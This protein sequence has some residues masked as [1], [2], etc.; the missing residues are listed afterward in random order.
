MGAKSGADHSDIYESKNF[1]AGGL[2]CPGK[3]ADPV[4]I[5]SSKGAKSVKAGAHADTINH[6]DNVS[7]VIP[8]IGGKKQSSIKVIVNKVECNALLD[9]GADISVVNLSFFNRHVNSQVR[10]SNFPHALT[11][12]G[13]H[14]A[15]QGSADI[16]IIID[17]VLCSIEAVITEDI[18][19]DLILGVDFLKS[20]QGRIDFRNNRFEFHETNCVPLNLQTEIPVY[21]NCN[22]YLQPRTQQIV[23]AKVRVNLP[24]GTC[25]HLQPNPKLP[26]LQSV[27]AASSLSQISQSSVNILVMNP[28]NDVIKIRKNQCIAMLNAVDN[29][30]VQVVELTTSDEEGIDVGNVN[31]AH[32][33]EC[34]S[35]AEMNIDI[36]QALITEEQRQE[37]ENLILQYQDI[38]ALT[39]NDIGRT[40][41]IMHHIPTKDHAPIRLRPYRESPQRREIIRK[42]VQQ[43]EQAGLITKATGAWAFPVVL[44]KK[45]N[46]PDSS[47]F[48]F[49]VD[50]RKLNA[51]TDPCSFPLPNIHDYIQEL[52][53]EKIEYM[54]SMDVKSAFFQ[55][56]LTPEAQE[57][58]TFITAD[59][60]MKFLVMP[61]GLMAASQTF[62]RFL[63][64]ALASL[65]PDI[66]LCYI[67]DILVRSPTWELHLEHLRR[68]FI[69]LRKAGIKLKPSKCQFVRQELQFLGHLISKQGIR[70]LRR[71]IEKIA[72]CN[73]PQSVKELQHW[74]GLIGFYSKFVPNYSQTLKPLFNLL[75]KKAP[76][77]FDEACQKAFETIKRVLTSFPLLAYANPQKPYRLYS[78]SSN[79][80]MGYVLTQ[81]DEEG[82]EHVIEYGSKL[83]DKVQQ[84]YSTTER[85]MQAAHWAIKSCR[86]FIL[87]SEFEVLVDHKSLQYLL[88]AK[89]LQGKL[90]RMALDISEYLPFKI[91]Y[92]AGKSL[93]NADAMS[94]IKF[95]EGSGDSKD[96]TAGLATQ[97]PSCKNVANLSHTS[98][99]NH[100]LSEEQRN[101]KL[102]DYTP[103]GDDPYGNGGQQT[104]FIVSAINYPG[105]ALDEIA[106]QQRD[107]ERL[108]RLIIYIE[109]DELPS[110]IKSA[111]KLIAQSELYTISDKGVLYYIGERN[112]RK[113]TEQSKWRLVIPEAL[114]LE[115]I[116][117]H[118]SIPSAAHFGGKRTY[119]AIRDN[120]FWEGMFQDIEK[121]VKAC[122]D[123]LSRKS[124]SR[125]I[126]APMIPIPVFNKPFEI[127]STDAVGPLPTTDRGNKY[128]ITFMDYA[129]RYPYA[130]AVPDI[131]APTVARLL[132]DEIITKHG[133]MRVILSDNAKNYNNELMRAIFKICRIKK[134]NTTS[135]HPQCNG[136]VE[137]FQSTLITA[138][139]K[140]VD[141]HGKDWDLY[142]QSVIFAFRTTPSEATGY[143]PHFLVHGTEANKI[144]DPS[145]VEVPDKSI[146][147]EEHLAR[148]LANLELAHKQAQQNIARVQERWKKQYDKKNTNPQF[149][150]FQLVYLQNP[151]VKPGRSRKFHLP[152]NGPYYIIN[153]TSPVN[154]EIRPAVGNSRIKRIVHVNRLKPAYLYEQEKFDKAESEVGEPMEQGNPLE[155]QILPPATPD[156]QDEQEEQYIVEEI[157]RSRMNKRK[158]QREF[159]VKWKD[160]PSSDN[161]WVLLEDIHPGLVSAYDKKGSSRE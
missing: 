151:H 161:S 55:I 35:L 79:V 66:A 142:L 24:E 122:P 25:C 94:R 96:K 30:Q 29:P 128:I 108:S 69:L 145:L 134:Q 18:M 89:N 86:P 109:T 160:Y 1:E 99:V 74:L 136:M 5:A 6:E 8:V 87:G 28:T 143:T 44:V 85:E 49:A 47:D 139:S 123:C 106:K 65:I 75:H 116:R 132:Y 37:L 153:Q 90:L 9:T 38:F 80:Q 70:P 63:Q 20:H 100:H 104:E 15:L 114:K 12:S 46:A 130:F 111:R 17:G 26:K 60:C 133:F 39:P 50:F 4:K 115:L 32:Q 56:P 54:S 107:D 10:K 97:I 88:T 58:A 43:M 157:L 113:L 78:D 45:Q 105:L 62:Q 138:L 144:S 103:A 154:Y 141:Q 31:S 124:P 71:N 67:D 81:Q 135:Y 146:T 72:S 152:W 126:R 52:G 21:L 158:G 13:S 14:I 159:L 23:K 34:K 140:F 16:P 2:A 11:A 22:T 77:K 57:K 91:T 95:T 119:D 53:R 51:I 33:K 27:I 84:N 41:L 73:P 137:R 127:I 92:I 82:I 102:Q 120:Y 3:N 83:L 36:S 131:R 149:S 117:V 150:K 48:R 68:T 93:G 76:Y 59:A 112:R 64:T 147:E 148:I 118:H 19:Y 98:M 101:I 42:H 155:E 7:P 125:K 121:F 110:S 129:T 156:I 61:F 40:S